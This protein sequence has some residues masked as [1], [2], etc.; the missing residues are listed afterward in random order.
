[1]LNKLWRPR[2]HPPLLPCC[3]SCPW[4]FQKKKLVMLKS[5]AMGICAPGKTSLSLK[6]SLLANGLDTYSWITLCVGYDFVWC[7]VWGQ[8]WRGWKIAADSLA[9]GGRVLN[10]SSCF[11]AAEAPQANSMKQRGAYEFPGLDL[12]KLEASAFSLWECLLWEK[13][14]TTYEVPVDGKEI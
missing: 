10:P 7:L 2:P 5:A 3:L 9:R 13:P 4:P 8:T 14:V 12:R 1:M 11:R 6:F